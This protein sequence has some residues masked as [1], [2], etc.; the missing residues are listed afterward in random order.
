VR[1]DKAGQQR[2]AAEVDDLGLGALVAGFDRAALAD[3]EDLAVLHRQRL[4]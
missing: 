1:V 4:G 2:L 3:C